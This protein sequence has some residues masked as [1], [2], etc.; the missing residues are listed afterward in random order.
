MNSKGEIL[1]VKH[2]FL[3]HKHHQTKLQEYGLFSDDFTNSP[4][5][6][7]LVRQTDDP[8][9]N[10]IIGQAS[11]AVLCGWDAEFKGYGK[12]YLTEIIIGLVT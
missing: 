11:F 12:M 6:L 10:Y 4:L 8:A 3:C 7:L 1:K 2:I 9:H 5:H